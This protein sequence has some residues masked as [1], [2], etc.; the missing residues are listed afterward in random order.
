M[1]NHCECCERMIR[2]IRE[3]CCAG[4][5]AA[6]DV[7]KPS[8]RYVDNS[9]SSHN[10]TTQSSAGE[11]SDSDGSQ[12]ES[13]YSHQ[14]SAKKAAISDSSEELSGKLCTEIIQLPP[15][16]VLLLLKLFYS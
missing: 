14:K 7:T 13:S 11:G 9:S 2:F 16:H 10:G 5:K 1:S 4:T 3:T 12:K 6:S 15:P 8:S